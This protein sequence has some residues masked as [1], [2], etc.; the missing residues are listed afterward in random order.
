VV[1]IEFSLEIKRAPEEVFDYL[2]DPRK[3]AQ[4]Q[5][6]AIEIHQES[7]GQVG[8][9]TRFRDVR[10][11]LGRTIESTTEFTEYDPPRT[12]GLKVTAGPIPFRI[13]QTLEP[14]ADGTR[15]SVHAEG[16]P[17]GFFKLA[18]PIVGRAAERQMKGDFETVKDLLESGS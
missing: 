4:W 10:K 17:G 16:E 11:L 5:A 13:R 1:T 9:G 8:V 7:E 3:V 18:E 2:A 14:A 15:V 6:W 12:L